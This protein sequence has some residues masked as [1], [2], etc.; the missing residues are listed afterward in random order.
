MIGSLDYNLSINSR[1]VKYARIRVSS[2]SNF[3]ASTILTLYRKIQ[4]RENSYC[5]IFKHCQSF[6]SAFVFSQFAR[7]AT[8]SWIGLRKSRSDNNFKWSDSSLPDFSNWQYSYYYSYYRNYECVRSSLDG[9]WKTTSCTSKYPF[10]CKITRKFDDEHLSFIGNC[11]EGWSK[12]KDKCY[13]YFS[14]SKPW[15]AARENCKAFGGNLATI[16]NAKQEWK[17]NS[18]AGSVTYGYYDIWIG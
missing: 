2:D 9:K 5:S 17:I 10:T 16:T 1:C 4:V 12:I 15:A 13:K 3:S 14:N 7:N 18:L 6:N 8:S 11:T